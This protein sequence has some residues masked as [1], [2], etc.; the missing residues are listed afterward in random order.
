MARG[1]PG[2]VVLAVAGRATNNTDS[3]TPRG[4]APG[5]TEVCNGLDD[6]CVGGADN[7]LTFLNYYVDVDG[8][9]FARARPTRRALRSPPGDDNSDCN[10]ANAAIKP[11]A[12]EV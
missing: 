1:E 10:D 11:G 8:D 3:T 2:D 12:V 9:G 6:D 5:A 4:G 7:G